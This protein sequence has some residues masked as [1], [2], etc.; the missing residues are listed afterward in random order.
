MF[1]LIQK[2][3]FPSNNYGQIFGIADS[4]V[5]TFKGTPIKSLAREICQNSLDAALEN[6]EPTRIEFKTFEIDPHKIPDY[7]KLATTSSTGGLLLALQRAIVTARPKGRYRKHFCWPAIKR[8]YSNLLVSIL[9]LA[10]LYTF[11]LLHLLYCQS[12]QHNIL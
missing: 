10:L 12:F 3:N 11:E 9:L 4:G 8:Y 7:S 2:W 1:N 5:E 6:G